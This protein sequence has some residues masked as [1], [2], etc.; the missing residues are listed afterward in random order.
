MLCREIVAIV[1]VSATLMTTSIFA[2]VHAQ[3]D[4]SMETNDELV[5]AESPV[6][7]DIPDSNIQVEVSWQPK[8]INTDEPTTFT[9]EFLNSTTG[10][11][12]QDVS[13][14][15]H[16][17]LDGKSLGHGHEAEAPDGVGTVEQQFYTMGSLSII[18]D[19]IAVG[20]DEPAVEGYAQF[21]IVVTPEFPVMLVGVVIT[22]IAVLGSALAAR[23]YFNKV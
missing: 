10:E 23:F 3:E 4:H 16:M 17:G 5:D 18:V 15:V 6:I 20:D 21:D 1:C 14:A 9:F 22:S 2:E 7:Y 12:L 11:H 13:Y 19:S 8:I